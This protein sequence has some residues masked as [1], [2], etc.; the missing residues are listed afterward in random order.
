MVSLR[1]ASMFRTGGNLSPNS[2]SRLP[3]IIPESMRHPTSNMYITARTS[4]HQAARIR[5]AWAGHTTP[6]RI[7]LINHGGINTGQYLQAATVTW[8]VP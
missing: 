8:L 3:G 7:D 1:L 5:I 6:G 2:N 4:G